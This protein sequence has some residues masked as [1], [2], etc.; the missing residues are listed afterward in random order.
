MTEVVDGAKDEGFGEIDLNDGF[1]YD[2]DLIA[3]EVKCSTYRLAKFDHLGSVHKF[4]IW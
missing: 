1:S 2:I 4:L 3:E